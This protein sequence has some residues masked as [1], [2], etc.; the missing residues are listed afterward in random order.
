MIHLIRIGVI[1]GSNRYDE[2][3]KSD[4]L[5]R[6]MTRAS[7]DRVKNARSKKGE[8]VSACFRSMAFLP[9]ANGFCIA[10]FQQYVRAFAK[11]RRNR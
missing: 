5:A 2:D 1:Y 11:R 9:Y 10:F 6:T 8:D 4:V 7:N 3:R